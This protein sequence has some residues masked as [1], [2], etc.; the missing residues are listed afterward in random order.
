MERARNTGSFDMGC[1]FGSDF[2]FMGQID[3]DRAGG[4]RIY[5]SMYS[6][7]PSDVMETVEKNSRKKNKK[8]V[9]KRKTNIIR[10]HCTV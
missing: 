9:A 3:S 4:T 7:W 1:F 10:L 2:T 6:V 5:K 8:T